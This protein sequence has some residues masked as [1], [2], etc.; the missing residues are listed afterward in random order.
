MPLSPILPRILTLLKKS[1]MVRI[2]MYNLQ[3]RHVQFKDQKK[4]KTYSIVK[5][6]LSLNKNNAPDLK[7][8]VQ[9]IDQISKIHRQVKK[10]FK[11]R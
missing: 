1:K 3:T 10:N 9:F 11:S 5:I 2:E 6:E 8:N 7:S 4:L